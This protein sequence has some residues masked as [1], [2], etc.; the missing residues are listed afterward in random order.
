MT[1]ERLLRRFRILVSDAPI[2]GWG[3][4]PLDTL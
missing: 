4:V 2:D 1:I 3:A